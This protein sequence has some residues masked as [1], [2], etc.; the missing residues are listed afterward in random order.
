MRARQ[1]FADMHCAACGIQCE[2]R[3][4][5]QKFCNACSKAHAAV[6]AKARARI[7]YEANR[8]RAAAQLIAYRNRNRQRIN[9]KQREAN[10]TEKRRAYQ[11]QWSKQKAETDPQYA[12]NR[13]IS[14]ALRL[15]LRG[16]KGGTKW[17]M[18]V[19]YSLDD[20]SR[21]L[22]RQF[23]GRIS[24]ATM[25]QWHI[26][27]ILPL[28]SFKYSSPHDADFKAAW[29]LT[30]LRPLWAEDNLSKHAKRLTLL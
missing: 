15:S 11:N 12:L 17:Q 3:G 25:G 13:R 18:L 28:S 10:R 21:H 4:T 16:F 14:S 22:E 27:H 26:D 19:G 30:N 8:E 20:L 24:W 2:R 6:R 9:A 5:K 29:A 23:A 1:I 7:W